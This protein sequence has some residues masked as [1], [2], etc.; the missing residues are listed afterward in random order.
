M[1]QGCL[2]HGDQDVCEFPLLYVARYQPDG[3]MELA[4]INR[5]KRLFC[6]S[7]RTGPGWRVDHGEEVFEGNVD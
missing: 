7:N 5:K 6:G 1:M 4:S 3:A 2:G